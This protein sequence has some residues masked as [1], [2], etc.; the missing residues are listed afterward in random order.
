MQAG[1]FVVRLY[2]T[3][4]HRPGHAPTRTCY[5]NKFPRAL[6]RL[7]KNC[8]HLY[9]WTAGFP[10]CTVGC[11]K[12]IINNYKD[13]Y[14]YRPSF[15]K[16]PRLVKYELE[17]FYHSTVSTNHSHVEQSRSHICKPKLPPKTIAKSNI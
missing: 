2:T 6:P 12:T 1:M 11:F 5:K 3:N 7:K 9:V 14:N 8:D 13:A 4:P 15:C 17:R 16:T 10:N